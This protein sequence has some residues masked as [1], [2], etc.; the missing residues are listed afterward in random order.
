MIQSLI[1]LLEGPAKE[2]TPGSW[3]EIKAEWPFPEKMTDRE[4]AARFIDQI[5]TALDRALAGQGKAF[6]IGNVGYGQEKRL[7]LHCSHA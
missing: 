7:V 1:E 2:L 5:V 4:I 6:S 3:V